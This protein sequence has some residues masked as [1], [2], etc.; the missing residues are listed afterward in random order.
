M[1]PVKGK[2]FEARRKSVERG[3]NIARISPDAKPPIKAAG[4]DDD[5][6]ALL[7][8]AKEAPDAQVQ[9]VSEITA[10]KGEK[11]R[12]SWGTGKEGIKKVTPKEPL[13]AKEGK[14]LER[15]V[16]AWNEAHEVKRAFV[17]ASPTVQERFISDVL[18]SSKH[19]HTKLKQQTK[20]EKKN[21][22][23]LTKNWAQARSFGRR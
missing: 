13:S 9:K 14:D 21:G 7:E 22:S 20:A 23:K 6:S 1:L 5:T 4:L 17:E 19:G 11:K 8:I 10:R 18:R 16:E 3:V 12:R 15:L 2:T